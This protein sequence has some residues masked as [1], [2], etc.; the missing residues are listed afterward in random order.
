M[1]AEAEAMEAW[2]ARLEANMPADG[3]LTVGVL[4]ASGGL[5]LRGGYGI[6]FAKSYSNA[7]LA[8]W[9]VRHMDAAKAATAAGDDEGATAGAAKFSFL[10][11]G[12]PLDRVARLKADG[13]EEQWVQRSVV[14]SSPS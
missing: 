13:E 11:G 10:D 3:S 5:P 12:L 8:M 6:G 4:E 14:W 7:V 9:A 2:F 1:S